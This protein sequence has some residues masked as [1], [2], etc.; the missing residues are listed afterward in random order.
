MQ[1]RLLIASESSCLEE[2]RELPAGKNNDNIESCIKYKINCKFLRNK[3]TEIVG[4][5]MKTPYVR[6]LHEKNQ[7]NQFQRIFTINEMIITKKIN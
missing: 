2:K 7:Q 6:N 4:E 1:K 5:N 3:E